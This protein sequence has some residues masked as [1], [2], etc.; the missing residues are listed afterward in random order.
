MWFDSSYEITE[1]ITLGTVVVVVT[2]VSLKS[3]TS[4]RIII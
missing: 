4:K 3:A 2:I 1:E